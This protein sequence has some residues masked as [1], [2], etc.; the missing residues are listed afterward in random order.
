MLDGQIDW[1][2]SDHACCLDEMKWSKADPTNIW[3]AKSGFGGT[4]YLLSGVVTEGRKRGLS[5]NHMAELSSWNPAQRFGL[6]SK[7]DIAPGF[8]ADS[9]SSIRTRASWSAPPIRFH[10][11]DIRLRRAGTDRKGETPS[12]RRLVHHDGKSSDRPT[13]KTCTAPEA[14]GVGNGAAASIAK[15]VSTPPPI[16][17]IRPGGAGSRDNLQQMFRT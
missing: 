2:F 11:K 15:Q 13:A 8:D 7:G 4:E 12:A 5:H 6:L 16:R 9:F 3:L 1:V 10:T 14:A 17:S